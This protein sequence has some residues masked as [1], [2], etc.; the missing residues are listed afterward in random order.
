MSN[1]FSNEKEILL[2]IHEAYHN[3]DIT[4]NEYQQLLY[5]YT[6]KE[7]SRIVGRK[8]KRMGGN[9][10]NDVHDEFTQSIDDMKDKGLA[11]KAS[12]VGRLAGIVGAVGIRAAGLVAVGPVDWALSGAVACVTIPTK[13][14][15]IPVLEP[16]YKT[17]T[18]PFIDEIQDK[19]K[20][21]AESLVDTAKSLKRQSDELRHQCE[22][23]KLTNE[24]AAKKSNELMR[25][26][27][28]LSKSIDKL[29]S[30]IQKD[31]DKI[32]D[33]IKALHAK[34]GSKKVDEKIQKLT[35]KS[36]T[37]RT[38][39]SD[40]ADKAQS[41]VNSS[42]SEGVLTTYAHKYRVKEELNG[43]YSKANVQKIYKNMQMDNAPE[44]HLKAVK[45]YMEQL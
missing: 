1:K 17:S 29:Q 44:N 14:F 33:K 8:I 45:T 25:N 15:N 26:I 4:E 16:I 39:K 27:E 18:K 35:A 31:I 41:K 2:H 24:E 11:S 34:K 23:G 32:D 9:L 13:Q 36:A 38:I 40:A 30:A 22:S 20:N 43:R 42:A 12:G 28:S 5:E 37:L 7:K 19:Y 6:L 21:K 10:Y 3:K